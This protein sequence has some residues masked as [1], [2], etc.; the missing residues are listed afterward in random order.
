L[1][2]GE[3]NGLSGILPPPLDRTAVEHFCRQEWAVHLDDVMLRRTGWHHYFRDA[4]NKAEQVAE[5]MAQ[6]AGWTEA[7]RKEELQNY[8]NQ[9]CTPIAA[10]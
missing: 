10:E 7:Q 6:F 8:A 5:W 3:T 4:R 1:L 9:F 2:P